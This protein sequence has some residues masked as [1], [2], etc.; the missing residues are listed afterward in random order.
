MCV[1][2]CGAGELLITTILAVTC[3]MCAAGPVVEHTE[4]SSS[5]NNTKLVH[6]NEK[7]GGV[8]LS[9]EAGGVQFLIMSFE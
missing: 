4:H 8:R 7:V 6:M 9:N 5:N 2:E 1:C 3:V